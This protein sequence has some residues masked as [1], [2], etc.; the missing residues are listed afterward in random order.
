MKDLISKAKKGDPEAFIT[1]MENC[2]SDMYKVAISILHND[3]DAADAISETI[4]KCWSE[5]GKLKK[6]KYFKTWLTRIL[7]NNCNDIIR[8][9]SH[10][11]YVESYDAIEPADSEDVYSKDVKDC[12]DALSENSRLIMLLYYTQGFK[13]KEI[14]QMLNMNENTVKTRLSRARKEFK[15]SY[16][17]VMSL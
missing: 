13:V 5:I 3:N 6:E 1:I 8:K 9:N 16:T 2:K 7:I 12:L 10:T 4:L 15:E 17:E 14:A 11:V